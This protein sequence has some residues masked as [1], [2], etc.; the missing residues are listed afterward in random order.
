MSQDYAELAAFVRSHKSNLLSLAK[1][2]LSWTWSSVAP[3]R[4]PDEDPANVG[5]VA[6]DLRGS[7]GWRDVLLSKLFSEIGVEHRR[8]NFYDVPFQLGHSATELKIK[9]KWMFFDATTGIY[10]SF[11]GTTVPISI[12]EARNNWSKVV[13]NRSTLEG[14]QGKF[15]APGRLSANSFRQTDDPFVF[16]PTKYVGTDNGIP[17]EIFSIYFGPKT[18]YRD[19]KGK[20][21][22]MVDTA[23]TWKTLTDKDNSKAWSKQTFFYDKGKL[24]AHYVYFDDQS[25][26]FT[27]Y[28]RTNKYAWEKKQTYVTANSRLQY[29]VIVFDDKTKLY[30]ANNVGS[31]VWA[32]QYIYYSEAG[33]A[34]AEIIVNVDGSSSTVTFD[35]K[36]AFAWFSHQDFID[37]SG[38]TTKTV[39][40]F[41]DGAIRSFDWL[42]APRLKGGSGADY[43]IGK[44]GFDALFGFAD[45]DT[46]DGGPGIDRMEGNLGNDVYHADTANDIIV[47]R[48]SEG[49]DTVMASDSF[50]LP[51]YVEN[52]ILVDRAVHGTGQELDNLIVGNGKNNILTGHG[53]NDRLLGLE[54]SDLLIGGAGNDTLEG[55]LGADI[56]HGGAGVDKFIWRTLAE[57]GGTRKTADCVKDFSFALGERLNFKFIDADETR[58]GNQ[59]FKF[60]GN[61]IF[62]APGQIRYVISGKETLIFLNTDNDDAAEALL[63][64]AGKQAPDAR[65]FI[66]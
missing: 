63:R 47:E 38:A 12:E 49:I 36:N 9:G 1:V 31:D 16:G 3:P 35:P 39:I 8:A 6:K 22:P 18:R 41:D 61:E 13:V 21:K 26:R 30:H 65:W 43:L 5:E 25:H 32:D 17:A 10:F 46:L 58:V 11:K 56:L 55:G 20:E 37:P 44:D 57:I 33:K 27:H 52:L 40:T 28:D 60:I 62:S 24:D 59:T 42:V 50:I 23:R 48:A 64:L 14:W 4:T 66:L 54:G 53:G 15:I 29:E 2:M 34:Q 19:D 7:C 45:N 51:R